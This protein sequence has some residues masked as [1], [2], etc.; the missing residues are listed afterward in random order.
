MV[1]QADGD[2]YAELLKKAEKNIADRF[3][4]YQA[5]AAGSAGRK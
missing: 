2:R 3:A 5:I 1:K 4:F